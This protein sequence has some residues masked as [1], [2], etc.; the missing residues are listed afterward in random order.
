[1]ADLQLILQPDIEKLNKTILCY[2]ETIYRLNGLW[3]GPDPLTPL[4][5]LFLIQLTFSMCFVHLLLVLLKPFNQPPFVTEI[6]GGILLG[7]SAFGRFTAYRRFLF[8]S[9]SFK[10]LEPMAHLSITYYAFLVGLKMDVKSVVRTGP[11]AA[12]VA[13]AGSFIPFLVGSAVY[14]AFPLNASS[15]AGFVFWGAALT[16]TGFSVL[17]RILDL[18]QLLHTEIGKTAAGAALITDISGWGLLAI[19]FAITSTYSNVEWSIISSAAY[20]LFC[21]YWLRPALGW[22]ILRTPEG[23]GYSEFYICAIVSGMSLSGVVADMCGTHPMI[24][25]FV[26][27]LVIPN[28]V[29]EAAIVDKLEDFV[30][31]IMMPVYAVVCGLRFNIDSV[32]YETSWFIVVLIVVL[33]C[34]VKI[35]SCLA[36]SLFADFSAGDA[37]AMGLLSN[38]KSIMVL[39]FLEAG[40]IQGVLSTQAY[41]IMVMAVLVMTVTVTPAAKWFRPMQNAVPYNRR[42]IQKAK[43]NEI[44]PILACIYTMRN[45]PAVINIL[46][47]S[48][49][50]ESSPIAV[51]A[52]HLVELVGRAT[53]MLIVHTSRKAGGHRNPSSVEAQADQLI[54]AFDNYELRSEGVTTEVL[55]ARCPYTTMDDDVCTIAEEKHAA[56]IVIPFHRQINE[57]GEMEDVDPSIRTVN[58]GILANAPCS[59]GILID[60][61]FAEKCDRATNIAVL[62]F[63]GADDREALAYAWRMASKPDVKLTVVRFLSS[64]EAA[65]AAAASSAAGRAPMDQIDTNHMSVH[66]DYEGE[67]LL[68]DDYLSTFKSATIKSNSIS[69]CE[70]VLNDEEEAIK[71][72]KSMDEHEHDLYMVGRGRGMLSPLTSGLAD[73]CDCPELGP[74]GDLLVTSEFESKFSVLV[75][76]QYTKANKQR[77]IHQSSFRTASSVSYGEEVPIRPSVSDSEVFES[78]DSFR[79]WNHED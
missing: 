60:R 23:Q 10:I 37:V 47:T 18:H 39:F 62:F 68:D 67:K 16:V 7:P 44:L 1:M 31:G 12:K 26:F 51:Y 21:A 58:E 29:L 36:V 17:T 56:F 48:N 76:Q 50:S 46:T 3:E 54:T 75:M 2:A 66:I 28:E 11:A 57:E 64:A 72:I 69:Y 52:L 14:F 6:I 49:A 45:V 78:F 20:V 43:S 5:S 38:A 24:G 13:V 25:A 40:Q 8:P 70:L 34:S 22:I 55:T 53:T 4:I 30:V 35:I 61:G 79:K 19:S 15:K 27:G 65:A 9:F 59:V 73:W 42:T 71:A 74:I 32:G 41:S 63:G 33:V 77:D